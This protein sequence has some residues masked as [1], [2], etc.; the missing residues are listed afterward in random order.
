MVYA[1]LEYR[2]GGNLRVSPLE[3][4]FIGRLRLFEVVW[5]SVL[6]FR[7]FVGHVQ[8][9]SRFLGDVGFC[10]SKDFLILII[11]FKAK[12]VSSLGLWLILVALI[13]DVESPISLICLSIL[14][15]C[16]INMVNTY[17]PRLGI[18]QLIVHRN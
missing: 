12:T 4:S 14:I 7:A 16:A 1:V 5:L 11:N 17:V 15:L 10:L 6:F 13:S 8:L 9:H 2:F 18:F 3:D